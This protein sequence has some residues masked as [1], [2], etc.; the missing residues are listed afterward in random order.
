MP[1]K[2]GG[3]SAAKPADGP[4]QELC[5]RVKAEVEEKHGRKFDTFTAVSYKTQMVN[6]TNY[7]VKVDVGGDEYYH[8]R[9]HKAFPH[10]QE[11]VTLSTS[12]AGKTKEEEITYI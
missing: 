5:D 2:C 3:T 12:H 10:E 7:F 4:V 6:G 8:V 9:I 11:K 1:N